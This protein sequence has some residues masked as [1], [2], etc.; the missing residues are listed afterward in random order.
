MVP[1]GSFIKASRARVVLQYPEDRVRVTELA[2]AFLPGCDQFAP[3]AGT[4]VF[5]ID[6]NRE[7]LPGSVVVAAR[8]NAD[9]AHDDAIRYRHERRPFAPLICAPLD[10]E[11]GKARCRKD[12]GVGG[13]PRADVHTRDGFSIGRSSRQNHCSRTY[14]QR[15]AHLYIGFAALVQAALA[16]STG[17]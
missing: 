13:L 6:V 7:Q 10:G 1:A 8:S 4:P 16:S 9:E 17:R 11:F 12:V 3:D 15:P 14:I 2:Q 5:G